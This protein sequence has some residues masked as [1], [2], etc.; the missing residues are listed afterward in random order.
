VT[1]RNLHGIAIAGQGDF[2]VGIHRCSRF[3][4]LC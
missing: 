4:R 3:I 1:A 2:G